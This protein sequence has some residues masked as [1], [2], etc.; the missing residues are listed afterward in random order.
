M[1]FNNKLL[2]LKNKHCISI[3][4]FHFKCSIGKFGLTSNKRE[5]DK[6]TP[7]GIYGLGDLFYRSDRV[8]KPKTKL[9]CL[10]INSKMGWCDDPNDKENY[11]KLIN[12]NRSKK[13]EKLYRKDSKYNYLI[14]ILYNTSKR[15]P[16]KGSAIFIHLTKNYN[17][18]AG[19]IGLIKKDF[20]ILA[21]LLKKNTKMKIN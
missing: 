15:T 10:K 2:I 21:R 17:P 3:D 8:L 7:K 6:K 12:I 4:D 5:G 20:L 11:N 9:N 19:C 14:P 1:K 16:Y 13:R 18:T